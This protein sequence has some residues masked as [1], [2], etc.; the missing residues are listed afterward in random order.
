[1]RAAP[2]PEFTEAVLAIVA[3]I[4][5]GR[6]MTY[7]DVAAVLGSRAARAVGNV[8][9][10]YGSDVPWWRVIRAS[11]LPPIAHEDRA[12][13]HYEAE[14]TPLVTTQGGYKV[15]LRMARYFPA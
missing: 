10:W 1:V 2:S 5:P 11:G 3:S 9:S 7:G 15:I 6:V 12:L 4:P 13:S 8:M 14:G